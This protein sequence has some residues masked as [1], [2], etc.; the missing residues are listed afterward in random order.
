MRCVTRAAWDEI[1]SGWWAYSSR[2]KIGVGPGDASP[3]RTPANIIPLPTS[4]VTR[5]INTILLMSL[6]PDYYEWKSTFK[7]PLARVSPFREKIKGLKPK[8][9]LTDRYVNWSVI[10]TLGLEYLSFSP[11]CYNINNIIDWAYRKWT[12]SKWSYILNIPFLYFI[13]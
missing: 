4:G 5:I 11:I 8:L 13:R 1:C 10:V 2:N 6:I 3:S 7:I 9:Y 12:I